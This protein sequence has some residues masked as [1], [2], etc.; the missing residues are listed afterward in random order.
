MVGELAADHHERQVGTL[1]KTACREADSG[2]LLGF[3]GV[4]GEQDRGSAVLVGVGGLV[5]ERGEVGHPLAVE[6]ALVVVLLRFA[7]DQEHDL[8]L[9]VDTRVVVVVKLLRVVLRGD[10]VTG[11]DNGKVL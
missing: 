4:V 2:I 10:S 1:L 8:A 6:G 11:E 3:L 5:T 9:D 7:T